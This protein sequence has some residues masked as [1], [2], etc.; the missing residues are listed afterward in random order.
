MSTAILY[1]IQTE[2]SN[3]AQDNFE[4]HGP[5]LGVL[6]ETGEMTHC[7][8]K[9]FQKI[10]G[11]DDEKFFKKEFTDAVADI[12]IYLLHSAAM[13][14]IS[15]VNEIELE[16]T[17]GEEIDRQSMETHLGELA[18]QVGMLLAGTDHNPLNNLEIHQSIMNKVATIAAMFEVSVVEAIAHTWSKVKQRNWKLNPLEGHKS[19]GN[20]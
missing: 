11:F 20:E 13:D 3:W 17:Y 9:R 5:K 14:R 8:L 7:I 2:I 1:V 19:G 4:F 18:E 12:G 15:L 6:E 10:R 16:D